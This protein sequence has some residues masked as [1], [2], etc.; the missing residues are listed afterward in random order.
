MSQV[1]LFGSQAENNAGKDRD[2]DLIVVSG[3]FRK[4]R[5]VQNRP[6]W[7]FVLIW[8]RVFTA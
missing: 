7:L 1:I 2:V 5:L 6:P 4:K 3:F 8:R